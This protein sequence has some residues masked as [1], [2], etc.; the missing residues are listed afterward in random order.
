MKSY[1][2]VKPDI[3]EL[4]SYRYQARALKLFANQRVN[5]TNAGNNISKAKGRGMDFDEVRHYQAGDDIRLMHWA[6][7][8]RLGK[9]YTKV[10]HEERERNLY[11]ILDQNTTM[12]FGTKECFKSVKAANILALL[13]FGALDAHDKVGGI[14]FDDKG[15]NYYAAKQDKSA[16]VKMFNFVAGDSKQ[17]QLASDKKLADAIKFLYAKIRSNSVVI[18][19]SDFSSFDEQAKQYLKL[20]SAKNAVI[21]IF[22]YD[23]IEKEL[24]ALDTFYFSDGKR[25]IAL[26]SAS[27]Q[28]SGIYKNL[29][30]NRY[31]A[32]KDF[33]R[34]NKT[35][36][37][38]VATNDDLIKTIN[39]GIA[40]YAN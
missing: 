36:F 13:G 19:I 9:P 2:G 21:N 30:Q 33:S 28:Q 23:P 34:K 12:N 37:I 26:D 4:L 31:T 40:S 25:R 14:I 27:K 10:Y 38:E 11:F 22:S 39:Y 24:P 8:A 29:Y 7:T 17:Y 5:T 35:G 20:L 3:Q 32:I 16:L 18:V 1:K 6:L 15:Y